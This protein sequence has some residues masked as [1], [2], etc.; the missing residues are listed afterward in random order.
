MHEQAQGVETLPQGA[1][2]LLLASRAARRRDEDAHELRLQAGLVHVL[3]IAPLLEEDLRHGGDDAG[4]VRPEDEDDGLVHGGLLSHDS[5]NF[6]SRPI[7]E[8]ALLPRQRYRPSRQNPIQ[9]QQLGRPLPQRR[10]VPR[11]RLRVPAGDRAG[12]RAGNAQPLEVR[13]RAPHQR[14]QRPERLAAGRRRAPAGAAPRNRAA[15]PGSSRPPRRRRDRSRRTPGPMRQRG[16]A[17]SRPPRARTSA[18]TR[19]SAPGSASI[20]KKLPGRFATPCSRLGTDCSGWITARTRP[21]LPCGVQEFQ[22]IWRPRRGRPARRRRRPPPCAMRSQTARM[23]RSGRGDQ[24]RRRARG[25]LDNVRHGLAGADEA[26]RRGR[27]A[28]GPGRDG[29]DAIPRERQAACRTRRRDV[30][31]R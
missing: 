27:R 25:R 18:R 17:S 19:R 9:L 23:V 16:S 31:R 21:R 6:F 12:E 3:E 1:Q 20:L 26:R 14:Q 7:R 30:R 11:D 15:S 28:P 24:H 2:Q 8:A 5:R 13:Q 4:P 29:D 10:D 22:R